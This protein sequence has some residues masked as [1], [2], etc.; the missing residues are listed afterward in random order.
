MAKKRIWTRATRQFLFEQLAERFGPASNWEETHKPGHGKDQAYNRFCEQFAKV[1]GA[2]SGDAVKI[3][4]RF[5][6]PTIGESTWKKG[7]AQTA[8]L[9]LAA[10]FEAGFIKD[11]DLPN[12]RAAGRKNSK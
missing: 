10:S 1:I 5:G 9:C 8:I 3:Q 12:L 2:N 7:Q 4:I 6:M 11:K